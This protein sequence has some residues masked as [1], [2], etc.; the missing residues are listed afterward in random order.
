[1]TLHKIQALRGVAALLVVMYHA[2]V[3]FSKQL[4]IVPMEG[5]F[6]FGKHGVDL[7]FVLSGF[8]LTWVHH[9]HIGKPAYLGDYLLKRA[10]RIYPMLWFASLLA[11]AFYVLIDDFGKGEKLDFVSILASF[12]ALPHQGTPLVNVS[13]TLRF[14]LFF[15]CLFAVLIVSRAIGMGLIALWIVLVCIVAILELQPSHP[16]SFYLSSYGVQFVMGIASAYFVRKF[17]SSSRHGYTIVTTGAGLFLALGMW[18]VYGAGHAY[19][20]AL[21]VFYGIASAL[22]IVGLAGLDI[23]AHTQKIRIGRT[24]AALSWLGAASYS[25]YLMHFSVCTILVKLL[26]KSGFYSGVLPQDLLFVI[27]VLLGTALSA[28]FY[29]LIELRLTRLVNKYLP[30]KGSGRGAILS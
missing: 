13:W 5:F 22:L 30:K 29:P 3:L 24:L 11:L 25:I 15:Y 14:E 21:R 9:Q 27:I 1:M 16:L 10:K 19:E 6:L 4:S 2:T 23:R 8:I 7:F 18:E 17:D 26:R 12:L 28:I 20:I